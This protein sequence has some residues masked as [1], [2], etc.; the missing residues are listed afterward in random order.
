[1]HEYSPEIAQIGPKLTLK[2]TI[3]DQKDSI[4]NK[5]KCRYCIKIWTQLLSEAEGI[6]KDQKLFRNAS[7]ISQMYKKSKGI[8]HRQS[9]VTII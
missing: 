7:K 3:L 2:R 9:D 5:I 1:M 4:E 8:E 6:S